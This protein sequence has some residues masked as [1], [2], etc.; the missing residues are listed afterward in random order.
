LQ[1]FVKEK[2]AGGE[3]II[4]RRKERRVKRTSEDHI[5]H[6]GAETWKGKGRGSLRESEY[7]SR[8]TMKEAHR[9][10]RRREAGV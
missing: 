6:L 9:R 3:K 2:L 10:G 1:R 8:N 5:P 4:R 7:L